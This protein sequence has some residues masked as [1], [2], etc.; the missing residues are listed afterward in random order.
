LAIEPLYGSLRHVPLLS[1]RAWIAARWRSRLVRVLGE[2]RQSDAYYAARPS[3]SAEA[4]LVKCK[5]LLL[6]PQGSRIR[7][8]TKGVC[9]WKCTV[10]KPRAEVRNLRKT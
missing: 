6:V 8:R 2:G 3:R 9:S 1:V 4:R 7:F 10:S 5:V